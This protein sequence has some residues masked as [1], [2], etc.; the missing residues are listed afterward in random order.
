MSTIGFVLSGG[1]PL[2]AIQV[3]YLKALTEN[4][5]AP[6]LVVGTSVGS[7]NAAH[8]ACHPGRAGIDKLESMWGNLGDDDLFPGGRFRAPWAR[9]FLRCT[10]VFENSGIRR[11]ISRIVGERSFE[12]T[13][14]P[15]GVTATDLDTGAEALF[16]SGRIAPSLLAS[17]ALPGVLPPVE[18][19]HQ[20]FIDGGVVN[21]VPILPAISMGAD[22]VY[23]LDATSNRS[24]RRHLERPFDHLMHA[25]SIARAERLAIERPYLE[26]I[27]KIVVLPKPTLDRVPSFGSMK[28]TR[29]LIARGYEAAST[30]LEKVSEPDRLVSVAGA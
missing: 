11:L 18:I 23:V 9:M 28:H 6:D 27:A 13:L 29:S 14:I 3:G 24:E 1:G 19:G 4:G 10:S 16:T 20:R 22:V 5:I 21:N 12:D 2:G 15:L 17:S 25:F 8:M 26:R 7:L 30:Y